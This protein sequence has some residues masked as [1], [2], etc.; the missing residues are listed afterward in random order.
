MQIDMNISDSTARLDLS[1]RFDFNDHRAFKAAYDS[2]LQESDVNTIEIGMMAVN[3]LDS[4]A[5][6]MLMLLRERAE[7]ANK[8]VVLCEPNETVAQ[9]FDIANFAK[10]FEIR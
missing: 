2:A 4:S 8:T 7:A 1:G 3:Y 6:G 5:L 9:I 10:L